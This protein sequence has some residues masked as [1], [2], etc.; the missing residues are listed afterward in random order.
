MRSIN[1]EASPRGTD[2][3]KY[4]DTFVEL[5]SRLGTLLFVLRTP[6][7]HKLGRGTHPAEK[8]TSARTP[9]RIVGELLV[10]LRELQFDQA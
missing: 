7:C 9:R 1:R 2:F 3:A 4:S 5:S 10:G 8:A 6:N